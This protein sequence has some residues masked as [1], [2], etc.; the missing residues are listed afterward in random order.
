MSTMTRIDRA[1]AGRAV[2]AHLAGAAAALALAAPALAQVTNY[3]G[4]S[5]LYRRS[6]EGYRRAT[7]VTTTQAV[8][9]QPAAPKQQPKQQT[10][11]YQQAAYQTQPDA[12][13][14]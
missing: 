10:V 14:M 5:D 11:T 4:E 9:H 8:H 12:A 7:A 2:I 13:Y 1:H 3:P 6:G